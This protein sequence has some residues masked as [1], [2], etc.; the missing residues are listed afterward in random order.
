MLIAITIVM[1]YIARYAIQTIY[2]SIGM[3]SSSVAPFLIP[4]LIAMSSNTAI[5]ALL[6]NDISSYWVY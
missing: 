1:V 6:A 3:K 5:G 2:G 4:L